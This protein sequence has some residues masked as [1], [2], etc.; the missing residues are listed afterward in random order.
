MDN[1]EHHEVGE[2]LMVIFLVIDRA[3]GTDAGRR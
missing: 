1:L 2:V 3:R